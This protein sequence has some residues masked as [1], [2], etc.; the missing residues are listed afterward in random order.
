M[1]KIFF[2]LLL[3]PFIAHSQSWYPI[4]T[5]WYF[6]YQEQLTFPA[7]GFTKYT[8]IKDTVVNTKPSKLI[9]REWIRYTGDTLSVSYVIVR[10]ENSKVYYY[11]NNAFQLMYDFTLNVGDTLAINLNSASC[12]SVSPLIVDSIKNINISGVNLKIQYVKCIYYYAG[13]WQ[14]LIDTVKYKIIER[15]G[16]D[17]SCISCPNDLYFDPICLDWEQFVWT[18]LRCYIDSDVFYS[19][20]YWS[21]HFPNYPCDTLINGFTGINEIA[22][23]KNSVEFFPNPITDVSF[24]KWGNSN[25]YSILI[26]TDILGR[27]IKTINVSGKS[28]ITINKNDFIQGLYLARLISTNGEND[29]I[30]FIIQ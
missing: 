1:K 29:V 13:A 21:A 22:N 25:S 6:N 7:D 11:Y 10:E 26:I 19:S 4:G 16:Y 5:T 9:K 27:N 12:D 20:Y 24:I 2:L 18:G 30:K 15:V 8:V 28:E 3:I 23:N 17:E 14:G